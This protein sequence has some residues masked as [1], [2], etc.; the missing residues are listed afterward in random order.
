MASVRAL[1]ER[2]FHHP[3]VRQIQRTPGT[4]VTLVVVG[5]DKGNIFSRVRRHYVHPDGFHVGFRTGPGQLGGLDLGQ[6]GNLR[7]P[8]DVR[9]DIRRIAQLKAPTGINRDP[10]PGGG[11]GKRDASQ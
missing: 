10:I 7:I 9:G 1:A 11:S 6:I 4:V 3:I 8:G 5:L 2:Q